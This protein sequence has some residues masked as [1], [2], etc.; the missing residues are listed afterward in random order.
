MRGTGRGSLSGRSGGWWPGG[1][2]GDRCDLEM[3]TG[4][5]EEHSW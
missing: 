1:G 2:G 4:E 5:E 3:N